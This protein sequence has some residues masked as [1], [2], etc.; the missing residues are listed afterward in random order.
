[1]LN[2]SPRGP[3]YV[4]VTIGHTILQDYTT[5]IR[6]SLCGGICEGATQQSQIEALFKC[7]GKHIPAEH[8]YEVYEVEG[9]RIITEMNKTVWDKARKMV[10]YKP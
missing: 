9:D 1:M 6:C 2:L 7:L 4:V 8:L 3:K 5:S 10:K